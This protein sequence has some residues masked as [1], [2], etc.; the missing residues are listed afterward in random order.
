MYAEVL[1][2]PIRCL[3]KTELKVLR[4]LS[5]R[6]EGATVD[7]IAG[8]IGCSLKALYFILRFLSMNGWIVVER[9]RKGVGRPK[10]IYKLSYCLE[11][12]LKEAEGCKC[13]AENGKVR[14]LNLSR[15]EYPFSLIRFRRILR[16][17]GYNECLT[18]YIDDKL[19]HD[20]FIYTAEK[21]GFRLVDVK[22]QDSIIKMTFRK[23]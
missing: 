13:Q 17:V 5:Q 18:I 7:E 16:T 23:C 22:S 9:M 21:K 3:S 14:I 1:R 6:P 10:N 4:Y 8:E 15:L 12:I 20:L 11:K 19:V 2:E